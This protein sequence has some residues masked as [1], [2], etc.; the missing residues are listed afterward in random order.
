MQREDARIYRK[1]LDREAYEYSSFIRNKW[2]WF[3]NVL[4]II[5]FTCSTYKQTDLTMQSQTLDLKAFME[6]C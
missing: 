5:L 1:K 3:I 4:L 2:L 6:D